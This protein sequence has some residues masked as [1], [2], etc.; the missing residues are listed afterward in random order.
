ME[1]TSSSKHLSKADSD[2]SPLHTLDYM[3]L[4]SGREGGSRKKGWGRKGGGR[5]G[6]KNNL[7]CR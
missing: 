1:P 5:D 2:A 3:R 6:E 7:T 4:G